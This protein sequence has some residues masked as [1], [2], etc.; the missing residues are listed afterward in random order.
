MANRESISITILVENCVGLA[1]LKAEHGLSVLIET[2][3]QRFLFDCGQTNQLQE[4][5][6]NLGLSLHNLDAVILSH[7]HYDHSGGL[8]SIIGKNPG[9]RVYGHPAVFEKKYISMDGSYRYIGMQY[10]KE[11][12]EKAGAKFMLSEKSQQIGE[13]IYSCGFIPRTTEFEQV[14]PSFFK[15]VGKNYI[16]DDI[17]DDNCLVVQ[18]GKKNIL[19]LGCTHSGIINTLKHVSKTWNMSGFLMVAGGM[20]LVDK[21]RQY[22]ENVLGKME[23]FN[24]D[25]VMPLHCSGLNHLGLFSQYFGSSLNYGSTGKIMRF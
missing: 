16:E 10:K 12:Y 18:Q 7:G 15:K 4:N 8:M 24:I 21:S 2:D 6:S 13:E 23:E 5:A 3:G 20:H 11:D 17:P 14:S 1:G 22:V 19:F 9:I 25:K